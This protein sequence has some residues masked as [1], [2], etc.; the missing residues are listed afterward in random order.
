MLSPSARTATFMYKLYTEMQP[1]CRSG[2]K[3]Y[4]LLYM[5]PYSVTERHHIIPFI[6]PEDG[7]SRFLQ[8]GCTF[9]SDYMAPHPSRQ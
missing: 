8:N 4:C 9:L 1:V 2:S 6:Y 5:I 7:G 3:D